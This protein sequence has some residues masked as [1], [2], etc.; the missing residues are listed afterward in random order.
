MMGEFEAIHIYDLDKRIPTCQ[1][2]AKEDAELKVGFSGQSKN[3]PLLTPVN[4]F[5]S[6]I[7]Y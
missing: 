4:S 2:N 7:I 6:I 1:L 3:L 5:E